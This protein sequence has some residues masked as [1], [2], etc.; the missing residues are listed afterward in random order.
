MTTAGLDSSTS[1]WST[2]NGRGKNNV[3]RL[4]GS[5]HYLNKWEMSRCRAMR[6]SLGFQ[7]SNPWL[8]SRLVPESTGEA[9]PALLDILIFTVS[10]LLTVQRVFRISSAAYSLHS[11]CGPRAQ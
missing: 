1:N 5:R 10:R 7:L 3:K 8:G 2:R 6:H 9:A 4:A 11:G